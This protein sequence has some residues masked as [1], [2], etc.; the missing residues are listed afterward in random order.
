MVDYDD[1]DGD[2]DNNDD[3]DDDC[4]TIFSS[5]TSKGMKSFN[6]KLTISL[7]V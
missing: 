1:D 4:Q 7:K 6:H 3:N 5:V 2:D